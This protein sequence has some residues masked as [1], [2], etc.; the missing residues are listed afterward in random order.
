MRWAYHAEIFRGVEDGGVD[1]GGHLEE[2]RGQVRLL[3]RQENRGFDN[4]M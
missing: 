4:V 3:E 1:F 2:L